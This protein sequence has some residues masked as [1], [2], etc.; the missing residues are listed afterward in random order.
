M[1]VMGA[2]CGFFVQPKW[3][4]TLSTLTSALS[5]PVAT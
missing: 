1:D 5:G 2:A 3:V 4:W